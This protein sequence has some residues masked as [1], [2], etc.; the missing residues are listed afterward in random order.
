MR[1]QLKTE[2]Q[3]SL[4]AS[5]NLEHEQVDSMTGGHEVK[6]DSMTGGHEVKVDSMTGGH[7]DSD[8]SYYKNP[9][10]TE[11]PKDPSSSPPPDD[12]DDCSKQKLETEWPLF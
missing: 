9:N 4:L 11:N 12:D 6:V 8:L 5:E 1:G 10:R 2:F 3:P 7:E